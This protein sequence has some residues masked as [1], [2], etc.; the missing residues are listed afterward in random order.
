VWTAEHGR[1][2]SFPF[3][4]RRPI[5]L[6]ARL[7]GARPTN[8]VELSAGRLTIRYGPWTL[9][10]DLRNVVDAEVTG[11]YDWYKVA[12]P[13]HLSFAD[14]GITFATNSDEGVCLRFRY[15]VPAALPTGLLRHPGAT[16]TVADPDGLVR[17]VR[18]LAAART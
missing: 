10:T 14:R 11:P 12:G 4:F 1:G 17:A 3:E 2:L 15:A 6:A 8:G 9:R 13:P 7:A 18:D 5:G 16:V